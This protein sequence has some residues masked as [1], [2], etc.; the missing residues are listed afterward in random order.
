MKQAKREKMSKY[1]RFSDDGREFIIK[2]GSTPYPWVNIIAPK[3]YGIMVSQGG[4]GVSWH[5]HAR[6]LR[7]TKWKQDLRSDSEGKF[8]FLEDRQDNARWG[9][10]PKPL[11]KRLKGYKCRHGLGYSVFEGEFRQIKTELTVFVPPVDSLEVWSLKITNN[12]SRDR[13]INVISSLKWWLGNYADEDRELHR[14]FYRISHGSDTVYARK[15]AWTVANE[16]G[17]FLNRDF[18]YTAFHWVSRKP[19]SVI[20]EADISEPAS[21]FVVNVRMKPGQT[22]HV[23]FLIGVGSGKSAVD[24]TVKKYAAPGQVE[25]SFEKTGKFWLKEL[26]GIKVDTKDKKINF[27]VNYWLKYQAISSRMVGKTGYY[28]IGGAFGFRDQLQDSQLFLY[29]DRPGMTARQ[30]KLN[31]SKQY[32]EG[33]VA[34]YWDPLTGDLA[35]CHLSDNL[36]WLVFVTL[37]YLKFTS[38]F[39]FLEEKVEFLDG[40]AASMRVHCEKAMD[41]VLGH[42]SRRG[43]PLIFQGDWNDG[44]STV[45]WE[46]KGESFWLGMFL[47]KIINDWDAMLAKTGRKKKYGKEAGALK[48]AVNRYGWDG[49]WFVRATKDSGEVI[50]SRKCREGKIFLNPQTWA[51]ISGITTKERERKILRSIEKYLY[52]DI[53]PLLLWPA[54]SRPDPDIGYLTRYAPGTRENGAVYM[55]AACWAIWAEAAAGRKDMAWKIFRTVFPPYQDPDRLWSEPYV[56]SAN[57]EGPESPFYG[58]GSWSWYTGSSQWMLKV[59]VEHLLD[60]GKLGGIHGRKRKPDIKTEI[61]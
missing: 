29:L 46:G 36:L 3:D 11:G 35:G 52:K 12:S 26:G 4:G 32:R 45:G 5:K 55:H 61:S 44:L 6:L 23:W 40:P 48:E 53:G 33:R 19:S 16:K 25:K 56:I 1:G 59:I 22:E 43:I 14:L 57:I 31:A 15:V 27:M 50:G 34:H 41:Y 51:I 24:R 49:D 17:Q 10:T 47:Y 2:N 58:R 8:I 54:Y 37:E 7:I 38:D 39:S 28:Q 42:R 30:I 21:G 13:D 20:N 60:K 18:P 9:T